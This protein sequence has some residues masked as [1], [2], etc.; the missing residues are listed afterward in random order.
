[1]PDSVRSV[2]IT[3][4]TR[5]IGKGLAREFL[6][7]GHN[8][9]FCGRSQES[10]DNAYADLVRDAEA[11]GTK[12]IGQTCDVSNIKHVQ[13]LWDRATVVLGHIDIWINN[14]GVANAMAKIADLD[15][16]DITAVAQTNLIGSINGC[17]VALN[18]MTEQGHGAIYNFEGFGSNGA[19]NWGLAVYG[20]SKY[21]LT[22]FTQCLVKETKASPVI[23]GC[24]SPGIVTT[25]MILGERNRMTPEQWAKTRRIYDILADDVQTVTPYLVDGVLNNQK[26]GARIAWLTTSKVIRRFL[27]SPF[28]KRKLPRGL[29]N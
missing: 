29:Q 16:T 2:V 18:G 4:A 12:V 25:D 21:A 9:C 15:P 14:A 13:N 24:M 17:H 10:V 8:V 19:K 26:H 11:N 7:R 23:V 1:M 22:Y 3:G 20:S 6:R 5:G 28:L 27:A